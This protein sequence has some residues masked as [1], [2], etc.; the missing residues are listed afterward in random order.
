[1]KTN[2][3]ITLKVIYSILMAVLATLC[4]L[5][6]YLTWYK[7]DKSIRY[8]LFIP[9]LAGYAASYWLYVWRKPIQ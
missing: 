4:L 7:A 1:M 9:I 8:V 2:R 3:V 6:V 5:T